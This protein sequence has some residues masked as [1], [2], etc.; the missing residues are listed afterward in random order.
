MKK[1]RIGTRMKGQASM[2]MLITLVGYLSILVPVVI[3][4]YSLVQVNKEDISKYAAESL[5][6]QITSSIDRIYSQCPGAKTTIFTYIPNNV[7][8]VNISKDGEVTAKLNLG[9]GPYEAVSRTTADITIE[10][11]Q[12]AEYIDKKGI[13]PISITCMMS[14]DMPKIVIA[15][16]GAG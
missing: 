9:T 11:T 5:V 14:K 13:V 8:Y 15:E 6:K 12:S 7:E 16:V 10:E 2:E 1:S 4:I 3:L